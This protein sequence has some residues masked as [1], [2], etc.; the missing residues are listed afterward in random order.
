MSLFGV[1]D[2]HKLVECTKS[3]PKGDVKDEPDYPHSSSTKDGNHGGHYP[4]SKDDG[5]HGGHPTKKPHKPTY[6]TS[7]IYS[8]STI[9]I[10]SCG[11]EVK[12]CPYNS[13][14][15]HVTYT[16]Y[17]VTTT[18][19]EATPTDD[20]EVE[21]P[22]ATS[23]SYDYPAADYSA[24]SPDYPVVSAD[25]SAASPEYPAESSYAPAPPATTAK[26]APVIAGAAR[27]AG[28]VFAAVA[29]VV[30]AALM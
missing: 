22:E 1:K 19:Y 27:T 16:D 18:V 28:G 9:T 13:K 4:T 2:I 11:P 24:A 30:V 12:D 5:H 25:Y 23:S 10:Y 8:K 26:P 21:Y 6:T 20:Y 14:N 29:G 3:M 15:P 7:T 17:P